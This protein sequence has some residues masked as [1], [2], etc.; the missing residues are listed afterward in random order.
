MPAND[1]LAASGYA[2]SNA[3]LDLLRK[4]IADFGAEERIGVDITF[5]VTSGYANAIIKVERVPNAALTPIVQLQSTPSD[6]G[7]TLFCPLS[8]GDNQFLGPEKAYATLDDATRHAVQFV[9]TVFAVDKTNLRQATA[10]NAIDSKVL[11]AWEIQYVQ[12]YATKIG[13]AAH[14][15]GWANFTENVIAD[16][17]FIS[18]GYLYKGQPVPLGSVVVTLNESVETLCSVRGVDGTSS[19]PGPQYYASISEALTT[20]WPYFEFMAIKTSQHNKR[21]WWKRIF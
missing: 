15:A 7:G 1:A 11:Q 17:L 16:S 3:E 20:A 14:E 4:R 18:L 10:K 19:M 12:S 2:F 8:F 6:H 21:P 13:D 5:G 9:R